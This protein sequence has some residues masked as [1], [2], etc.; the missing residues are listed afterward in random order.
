MRCVDVLSDVLDAVKMRGSLYF[1]TDF[2]P[3]W[4]VRVPARPR[5]ARFHLV[6]RG[7]CWVRAA[8]Q[9][10]A[11]RLEA[12]D[13]V[14]VPHGAEHT[15]SDA[16]DTACLTVDTILERTGF[17][18]R[19]A[20]VHGGEDAGSPTRLVCG[21]LAFDEHAT[22]PLLERLPPS[23][24]IEHDGQGERSRLEQL[25]RVLEREARDARPGGDAIVNR[26]AEAMFIQAIRVWAESEERDAGLM[27]ALADPHLARSLSAIHGEPS[28]RWSLGLLAQEARLSRTVFAARFRRLV[29]MPP[30]QYVAFWRAQ[31]ARGV[32]VAGDATLEAIAHGV[33]YES[34]AAFCRIFKKWV[35]ES[36]GSYRRR[37]DCQRPS[38]G[39]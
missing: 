4:G 14:L 9:P 8:G 34:T 39:P 13:L 21:Y 22:H 5:L 28:R 23:M 15:L 17:T 32:L 25:Y 36:P 27:A 38:D 10:R 20:L 11:I 33:G 18:G 37:R 24:V 35:G 31:K 29:G 3:P 30:M 2:H 6:V 26:L 12:G 16:P 1:T 7:A 19:G